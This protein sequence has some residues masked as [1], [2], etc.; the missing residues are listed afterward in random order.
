MTCMFLRKSTVWNTLHAV[1][2]GQETLRLLYE[3]RKWAAM[4]SL[5]VCCWSIYQWKDS[6]Q[7]FRTSFYR[8][9]R[10]CVTLTVLF[11]ASYYY[12][13]TCSFLKNR[14]FFTFYWRKLHLHWIYA[15]KFKCNHNQNLAH[16][17]CKL[18]P[19]GNTCHILQPHPPSLFETISHEET[20]QLF[21]H[22]LLNCLSIQTSKI[23][24]LTSSHQSHLI[25][26]FLTSV[27]AASGFK[28]TLQT[29]FTST[30][31]SASYPAC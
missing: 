22:L 20:L 31:R 30:I 9:Q 27:S 28:N 24:L 25:N 2:V 12:K 3:C 8:W 15:L 13:E 16:A 1:W 4:S 6:F 11:Q 7:L 18:F 26:P 23:S 5:F 19:S 17:S 10:W 14:L 21:K 29:L